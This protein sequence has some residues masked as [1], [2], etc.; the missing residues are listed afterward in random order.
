MRRHLLGLSIF[1]LI[2]SVS[3][4]AYAFVRSLTR[5]FDPRSVS[6]VV[7]VDETPASTSAKGPDYVTRL[8]QYDHKTHILTARLEVDRRDI[9]SRSTIG[10][11]IALDGSEAGFRS[12][13][14]R[15]IGKV[16]PG[17]GQKAVVVVEQTVPA[18]L[19]LNPDTNHYA[20]FRISQGE[21]SLSTLK[22]GDFGTE[23]P[24]VFVHP[25]TSSMR[26]P[27]ILQ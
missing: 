3:V 18:S 15:S 25:R 6:P 13:Y 11:T 2:V 21:D 20:A 24:V 8:V 4:A 27:V 5:S 17:D 22:P 1:L 14:F 10:V 16:L 9:H 23:S 7:E 12:L 26:G 19:Q